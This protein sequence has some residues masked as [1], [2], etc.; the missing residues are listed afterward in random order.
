MAALINELLQIKKRESMRAPSRLF[1][2]SEQMARGQTD[3]SPANSWTALVDP[4]TDN[5]FK[6]V[7]KFEQSLQSAV[8]PIG[9]LSV[10]ELGGADKQVRCNNKTLRLEPRKQANANKVNSLLLTTF[11]PQKRKIKKDYRAWF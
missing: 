2:A 4:L 11:L 1:T 8:R 6:N 10:R 5:C 7:E 3:P 9:S